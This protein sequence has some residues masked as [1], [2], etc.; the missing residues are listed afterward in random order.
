M[1]LD[2]A[3]KAVYR[4]AAQRGVAVQTDREV[5]MS[6]D[7]MAFARRV[8][9]RLRFYEKRHGHPPKIT[10]AMSRILANDPEYVHDGGR[11]ATK[12]IKP[13]QNPTLGTAVAIAELLECSV[14]ELLGEITLTAAEAQM[15]YDVGEILD[16]SLGLRAAKR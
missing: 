7:V 10:R 16:R 2:A 3:T 1:M 15:L 11:S 6:F 12:R 13:A 4:G 5:V 9:R 14:G 8:H